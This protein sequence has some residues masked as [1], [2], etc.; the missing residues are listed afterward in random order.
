LTRL[1]RRSAFGAKLATMPCPLRA[2]RADP[3]R[4][5]RGGNLAKIDRRARGTRTIRAQRF[6]LID[7]RV[8]WTFRRDESMHCSR[9]RSSDSRRLRH[10]RAN[11]S[12]SAQGR[13]L[14]LASRGL[15][16]RRRSGLAFASAGH[17]RACGNHD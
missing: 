7:A 12:P 9:A 10:T 11:V 4:P 14:A 13:T 6:D 15:A 17:P 1:P 5:V 3:H 8:N 16:T 2:S